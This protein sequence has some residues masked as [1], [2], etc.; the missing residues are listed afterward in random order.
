MHHCTIIFY[1]PITKEFCRAMLCLLVVLIYLD[2]MVCKKGFLCRSLIGRKEYCISVIYFFLFNS[3]IGKM[4]PKKM[5]K[6]KKLK[7]RLTSLMDVPQGK[8]K[9]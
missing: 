7:K 2:V 3:K 9:M 5:S 6:S 8:N 4:L 1:Y